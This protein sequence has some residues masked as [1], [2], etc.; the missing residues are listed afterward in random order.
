LA[1]PL[2]VE[3]AHLSVLPAEAIVMLG[4]ALATFVAHRSF[5]FRRPQDASGP[6]TLQKT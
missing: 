6:T 4:T 1:L 3:L 5:T 2:L